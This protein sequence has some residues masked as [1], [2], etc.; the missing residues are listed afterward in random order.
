[1]YNKSLIIL[2][3]FILLLLSRNELIITKRASHVIGLILIFSLL[4]FQ[5][6]NHIEPFVVDNNIKL[7]KCNKYTNSPSNIHLGA[8][9]EHLELAYKLCQS[10]PDLTCVKYVNNYDN[11]RKT[12]HKLKKE[13]CNKY[14]SRCNELEL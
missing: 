12:F 13:Y 3:L 11:L 9:I 6:N 7:P 2:L 5:C 1:M 4:L 14:P 8:T 10:N